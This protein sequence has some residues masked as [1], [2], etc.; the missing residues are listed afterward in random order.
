MSQI[1]ITHLLSKM[2]DIVEKLNKMAE[3]QKDL[4]TSLDLK[5]LARREMSA[6]ESV[7]RLIK[8]RV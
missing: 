7:E 4:R 2:S 8:G 5:D 1:T 3:E 6:R